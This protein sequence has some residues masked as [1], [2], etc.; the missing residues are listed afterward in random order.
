MTDE[1]EK[2]PKIEF[3]LSLDGQSFR[4]GNIRENIREARGP[5]RIEDYSR[6]FETEVIGF[7]VDGSAIK[8]D[9]PQGTFIQGKDHPRLFTGSQS[10]I[11]T[12]AMPKK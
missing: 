12:W 8:T 1:T 3:D 6:L 5:I 9:G 11:T 4:V 10:S 7:Q 2:G